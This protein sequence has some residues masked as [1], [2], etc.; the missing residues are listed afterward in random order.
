MRTINHT[1]TG[2]RRQ[3]QD[4]LHFMVKILFPGFD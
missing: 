3:E 1:V 4:P 2:E